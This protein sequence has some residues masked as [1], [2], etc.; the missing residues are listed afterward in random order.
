MPVVSQTSKTTTIAEL[1]MKDEDPQR[2]IDYLRT[3]V[4]VYNRQA[5]EDK[6]EISFR[7][8]QFIN[9]RLEKINNELGNT[10][11]QLESYK[12]RNNVVE[13]KLNATAA[14]ANS[15]TYA[16]KLQEA[17]T[18]VEL[19]NE[20]GKYMNEP[21]NRYQ[22]IPSNVGLTDDILLHLLHPLLQKNLQRGNA[23]EGY[24]QQCAHSDAFFL[25]LRAARHLC[26]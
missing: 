22:P 1:V 3:L 10:E 15:D 13:M 7:T 26:G 20:L 16:Q 6:N 19:L 5:N 18:Q 11:G 17:N 23:A 2:S 21:G 25:C 9:Q 12:K 8:E 14:I 24:R 4:N